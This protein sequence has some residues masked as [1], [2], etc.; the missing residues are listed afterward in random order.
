MLDALMRT[1]ETLKGRISEHGAY[2]RKDEIRTR[3]CL[4]D[5]LLRVLGWEA[6]DPER[7]A[8]EYRVGKQKADY[9]LLGS[10]RK[11]AAVVE[12]KKL[13]EELEAHLDQMLTYA[14][15]AGIEY[16]G[17]TDGDRWELYSVF[18][19]GQLEDRRIVQISVAADEAYACALQLLALWRPNLGSEELNMAVAPVIPP[20]QEQ[21]NSAQS[22]PGASI[23]QEPES[24][25][26]DPTPY[27]SDGWIPLPEYKR[28][29]GAPTSMRMPD[30]VVIDIRYWYEIFIKSAEWLHSKEMLTSSVAAAA[31][32]S[33]KRGSIVYPDAYQSSGKPLPQPVQIAEGIYVSKRGSSKTM[34]KWTI[35]LYSL[36]GSDSSKIMV[37]APE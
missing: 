31:F 1:I 8:L 29:K 15:R 12:A 11:P 30:G 19:K 18:E 3:V 22:K 28:E 14:N 5:P 20:I 7:V 25:P 26:Q 2:L 13:G 32:N 6:A 36:C 17:V 34:L 16:A 35:A 10:D 37:K 23:P 33:K 9:A 24:E 27:P 21:E 4:I